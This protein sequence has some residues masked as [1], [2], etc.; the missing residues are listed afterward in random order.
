[1]NWFKSIP[2]EIILKKIPKDNLSKINVIDVSWLLNPLSI[3]LLK[4]KDGS[5]QLNDANSTLTFF[6][7]KKSNKNNYTVHDNNLMGAGENPIEQSTY[8]ISKKTA[9]FSPKHWLKKLP[10]AYPITKY[11]M[12]LIP[13]LLIFIHL[14]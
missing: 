7:I 11:L 4:L 3:Y 2:I 9:H 12:E 8:I 5:L 13:Y 10:P 1:M 14:M 6:L